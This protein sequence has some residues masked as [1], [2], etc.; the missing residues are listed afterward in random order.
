M[1]GLE[2]GACHVWW[3]TV[4][5][6]PDPEL[7]SL[8]DEVER[9][10]LAA[11]VRAEDRARF[12]L[13]CV[14]VRRV[15]GAHLGMDPAAVPLDRTCPDCGRP[16]GK[17]RVVNDE[18]Q[19]SVSHS[20]TKVVVAIHKDAPVGIDVERVDPGIDV[21]QLASV[22]LAPD[23]RRV[24]GGMPETVRSL[25]FTTYWT[26]KEAAVKATGAGLRTE[27]TDV[28]VSGPDQPARLLRW[29]GPELQLHDL[30]AGNGYAA[31]LAIVGTR[32]VDVRNLEF[33]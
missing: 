31:A 29:S 30:D 4:D 14:I 18:A 3:A 8:L 19:V 21:D 10:R 33:Q 17:V 7:G 28:V 22:V 26:R 6:P 13:G 12:L 27:L 9:A 25:G 32:P 5:G 16:H 15:V 2:D 11:Y 1:T 24:L 23:E 20:G